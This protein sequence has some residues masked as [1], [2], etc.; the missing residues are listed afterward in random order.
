MLKKFFLLLISISLLHCNSVFSHCDGGIYVCT[1]NVYNNPSDAPKGSS[2]DDDGDFIIK[3]PSTSDPFTQLNTAG[4][5]RSKKKNMY[6]S[7]PMGDA[8]YGCCNWGAI[9][10][11]LAGINQQCNNTYNGVLSAIQECEHHS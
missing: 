9:G 8:C 1:Y 3:I 4:K 5:V 2:K 7:C 11:N 6:I 10:T